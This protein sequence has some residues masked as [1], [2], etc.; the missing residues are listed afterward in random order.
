[1]HS[2]DTT[3]QIYHRSFKIPLETYFN[4]AA[5]F[6]DPWDERAYQHVVQQ[7]LAAAHDHGIVGMVRQEKDESYVYL[8]AAIRYPVSKY[9]RE[10]GPLIMDGGK[11]QRAMY[12]EQ[13]IPNS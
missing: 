3:L 2:P 6:S 8:D 10:K 9:G 12:C 13:K 1:M 7:S 11:G 5:D 4:A